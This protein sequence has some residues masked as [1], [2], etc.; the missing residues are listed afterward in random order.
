MDESPSQIPHP[1]VFQGRRYPGTLCIPETERELV[2]E[3][4][5]PSIHPSQFFGFLS[6]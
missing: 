6:S 4:E 2:C 1:E 3:Q 5:L